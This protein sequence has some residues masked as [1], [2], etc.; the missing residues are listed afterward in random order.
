MVNFRFQEILQM[1]M[2]VRQSKIFYLV[3]LLVCNIFVAV[4]KTHSI[5]RDQAIA[6]VE[7]DSFFASDLLVYRAAYQCSS[8]KEQKILSDFLAISAAPAEKDLLFFKL[9]FFVKK[10]PVALGLTERLALQKLKDCVSREL[11][12]EGEKG[13]PDSSRHDHLQRFSWALSYL[14]TELGVVKKSAAIQS[15]NVRRVLSEHLE[16][17]LL[18]VSR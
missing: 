11:G 13:S 14:E 2:L 9:L 10:T 17:R 12:D 8:G 6:Q 16:G 3:L 1:S 4:A 18:S 15:A 5:Y 7:E